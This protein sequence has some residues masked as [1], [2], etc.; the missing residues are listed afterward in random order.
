MTVQ[1]SSLRVAPELDARAYVAGVSDKVSADKAMIASSNATGAALVQTETKIN[2]SGDA[3]AR[4][5]R[6]YIDGY[7][8]EQRFTSGL[9]AISR[10]L[11]TGR[12]NLEGAQRLLVG[13]QQRLGLVADSEQAAAAGQIRLAAAIDAA[14]AQIAEQAT[15]AARDAIELDRMRTAEAAAARET[16]RMTAGVSALRAQLNPLAAAQDQVNAEIAEYVRWAER[17]AISAAEL[18]QAQAMA[19]GRLSANQNRPGG[20]FAAI[21]AAS[22]FQDIAVT[23][24]MGQSIPII[25][26]QQGTQLAGQLQAALGEQGAAGAAKLL[27]SALMSLASPVSLIAIGVTAASAAAIQFFLSLGENARTADDVLKQHEENI[28]RLGPAYASAQAAE[29]AYFSESIA[30]ANLRLRA[31]AAEA[32]KTQ[33]VDA[34]TAILNLVKSEGLFSS[35]FYDA[36]SAIDSF[37]QS[38]VDGS[39]AALQFQERIAALRNSGALTEQVAQDLLKATNLAA[40]TERKLGSVAGQV[41][42]A[43]DAFARMQA[44][45]QGINPYQAS[46]GLASVT[47]RVDELS[48]QLAAGIITAEQFRNSLADLSA[49]SPDFSGSIASISGLAD[50]MERATRAAQGFANTTAKTS[51]PGAM[52]N[53][54]GQFDDAYTMWRRFG[55]DADTGVDPNNP[56]IDHSADLEAKRAEEKLRRQQEALD[57]ELEQLRTSLMTQEELENN[58]YAT[59]ILDIQSFYEQGMIAKQEY[60][61]LLERAHIDHEDRMLE[62]SRQRAEQDARIRDAMYS[63]AASTFG[64]LASAAE[65]FG[66]KGLAT[67]KAF[68]IAQALISTYAGIAKALD[69]PWPLNFVIAASVAAAGFA[70]VANIM[71]TRKGGGGSRSSSFGGGGSSGSTGSAAAPAQQTQALSLQIIGDVFPRQS[72]VDLI[73]QINDAQKDGHKVDIHLKGA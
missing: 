66:E 19:S 23:A 67:A 10:G 8:A 27:G 69:N 33:V 25:A 26:L 65:S 49:V 2:T 21:G 55:Y 63:Y 48:K 29:K 68:G 72:I 40:D 71:S 52:D 3:I 70:Q 4:L 12:T 39:P 57:R 31:D 28:R 64:S 17:G 44:Q 38:V 62:I 47:S 59:R 42:L 54:A 50:Q 34:Q 11:E 13:M 15:A 36:K 20:N 61:A 35:R 51:R 22:Q 1:L 46:S 45:I 73:Q 41:D 9:N 14:N 24:A 7:V 30:L 43:A 18:A 16:E 53:A 56:S 37:V 5:S 32:L 58:S 60:D 6:Q